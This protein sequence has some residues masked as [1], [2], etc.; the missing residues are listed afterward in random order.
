MIQDKN[1]SR[2]YQRDFFP[3][4]SFWGQQAIN[5]ETGLTMAD[6]A[7]VRTGFPL[8]SHWDYSQ[9]IGIRV[10]YTSDGDGDS[11]EYI[12][13]F[14]TAAFGAIVPGTLTQALDTVIP[15]DT[16]SVTDN[17]KEVTGWGKIDADAINPETSGVDMF[18]LEI[19]QQA[20][21]GADPLLLGVE[22]CFLP[23]ITTNTTTVADD[24]PTDA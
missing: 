8:P 10:L 21:P 13:L 12:A 20:N 11:Q 19:E 6:G 5:N 17:G 2:K 15:V 22:V 9:A 3:V 18:Y 4:Q 14:D 7:T 1:I 24:F 23:S 16:T